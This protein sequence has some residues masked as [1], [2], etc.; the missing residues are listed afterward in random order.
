MAKKDTHVHRLKRKSYKTGNQVYFCTK[1]DCYF[2]VGVE[3]SLGK[4]VECWRCGQPFQMNPYSMRLAKP[5]CNN[6]HNSKDGSVSSLTQI[7]VKVND[8]N[9][10]DR[11]D[12][13]EPT[14]REFDPTIL[15]QTTE[16][17][18]EELKSK[19]E[20]LSITYEKNPIEYKTIDLD[21][22]DDPEL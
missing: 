5:H 10:A 12:P 15:A 3:F 11:R 21:E 16:S 8:Y 1:P 17:T 13:T 7:P 4:V 6:C 22:V 2:K 18:I 14:R 20:G 9:G 19:L